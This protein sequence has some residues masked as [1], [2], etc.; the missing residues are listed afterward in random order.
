MMM[1][2]WGIF[3]RLVLDDPVSSLMGTDRPL[4]IFL[5]VRECCSARISVGAK[6]SDRWWLRWFR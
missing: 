3:F 1:E 5:K 6:K 4:K 2:F